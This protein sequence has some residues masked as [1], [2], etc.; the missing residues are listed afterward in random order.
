MK[1]RR[2]GKH[3]NRAFSGTAWKYTIRMG[4]KGLSTKIRS[5]IGAYI[6][7]TTEQPGGK[8]VQ[9]KRRFEETPSLRIEGGGG[10][11]REEGSTRR[12]KKK[13]EMRER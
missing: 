13:R 10:E 1:K 12:G 5:G 6:L 11:D 3:E 8:L 7:K 9:K 2:K 4:E